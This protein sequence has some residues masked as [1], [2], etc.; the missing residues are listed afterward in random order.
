M[1]VQHA[2]VC[3][4]RYESDLRLA[5]GKYESDRKGARIGSGRDES[6]CAA[7]IDGGTNWIGVA[8]GSNQWGAESDQQHVWSRKAHASQRDD[9]EKSFTPQRPVLGV[10]ILRRSDFMLQ[11]GM[12][13]GQ[14]RHRP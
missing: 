4:W 12:T 6:D 5:S 2:Y 9:G 1:R 11:A 8:P 14:D 7:Q 13:D 3:G 10:R